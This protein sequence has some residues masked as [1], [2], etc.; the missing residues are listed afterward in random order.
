M[1]YQLFKLSQY[2]RG[3]I[4]YFGISKAIRFVSN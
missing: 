4:N 2:L 3:W 1:T